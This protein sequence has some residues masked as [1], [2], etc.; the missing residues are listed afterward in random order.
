MEALSIVTVLAL[1][2]L[3]FFALQVGAARQRCGISAPSVAG[4]D[5]FER[6]YRVHQNT[7]EQLVI[8]LPALWMFG[9]FIDPIW[10]AGIGSIFVLSRF[11]YR[12]AYIKDPKSRSVTFTVGFLSM[13]VLLLGSIVG[14]VMSWMA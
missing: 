3:V 2:Q 12:L 10:G 8:F 6:H 9:Y 4:D 7:L 14:A 5:D 1:I 11:M 13:A